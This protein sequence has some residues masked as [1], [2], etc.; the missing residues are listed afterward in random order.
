MST[1][2]PV[3]ADIV[4]DKLFAY[5]QTAALKA[6]IDLEVFTAIDEGARTP[7]AIAARTKASERGIRILCDFL[8]TIDLLEKSDD[9]YALTPNAAAFLSK[10]SQMYLGTMANFLV[11]PELKRNF[12]NLTETVRTGS[13]RQDGN[14]V[15]AE[16]PIWLE[17]ARAMVPMAVPAA[18]AIADILG[19]D[20]MGP[21]R[22]LDIAAGH[23]MYG[24]ILAQRNPAV[25]VSA[26]DWAPVLGVAQ[27]HAR[28][29]GVESRFRQ[30]AGD[31]FK[32]EFG[33]GFDIALITNF[34]HHFDA[35]QNTAFLKKVKAA[36]APSGRVAIAEFVPNDDRV[37]P[38]IPAR[39]S[40]TMLAG[41]PQGDAYTLAQ[42][43]SMLEAAGFSGVEAHQLP[44]PQKIIVARA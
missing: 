30:I 4:F 8:T 15:S 12:D 25:E 14:T 27:E 21:T 37:T 33:T 39:F 40:L 6:A 5:Q 7:N 20:A 36:L 35:A 26:A 2:A 23:G 13:V 31:A 32:T 3:S 1:V 28:Q 44:T 10:R 34:L 42:L 19:V 43:T 9:L 24:I 17:F 18:H 16:N 29:A 22:V 38:L 11:L 41:T